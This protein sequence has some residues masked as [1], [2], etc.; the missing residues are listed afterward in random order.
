MGKQI[1]INNSIAVNASGLNTANIGTK[2][3]VSASFSK[4]DT[5]NYFKYISVHKNRSKVL[6]QLVNLKEK[7]TRPV[8]ESYAAYKSTDVK[9]GKTFK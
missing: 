6:Q 9:T 5:E 8:V 2:S 7:D 1:K 4:T 3:A